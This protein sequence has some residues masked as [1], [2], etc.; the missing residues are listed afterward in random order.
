M[1]KAEGGGNGIWFDCKFDP[2]TQ[3]VHKVKQFSPQNTWNIL[4]PQSSEEQ[5]TGEKQMTQNL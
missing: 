2:D 4:I 5:A 1:K 3:R